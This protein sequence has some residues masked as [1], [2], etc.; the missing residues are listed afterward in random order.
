MEIFLYQILKLVANVRLEA[1]EKRAY[2]E[3]FSDK[4][5]GRRTG[6]N[7]NP[8]I[9]QIKREEKSFTNLPNK[10]PNCLDG[11]HVLPSVLKVTQGLYFATQG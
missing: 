11:I 10:A 2:M 6:G 1:Y 5:T 8:N 9:C 3:H 7:S 4:A